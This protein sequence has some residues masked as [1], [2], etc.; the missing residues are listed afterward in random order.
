ML[1]TQVEFCK[2][3]QLPYIDIRQY[4]CLTPGNL[5]TFMNVNNVHPKQNAYDRW[6]DIIA[7]LM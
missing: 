6:A 7:K 2:Y 1:N 4:G 3:Y 5:S